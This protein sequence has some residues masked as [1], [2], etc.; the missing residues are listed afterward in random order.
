[1]NDDLVQ[2]KRGFG[3]HPHSNAEIVTYI[4][5][6]K[7][8]H[9]DSMHTKETLGPGSIQFMTAGSGVVH[10]EHNLQDEPLRFIQMWLTPKQRGLEPNYG[11]MCGSKCNDEKNQWNHLVSST[12]TKVKTPVEINTDANIYVAKLEEGATVNMKLNSYRQ[13][14]VLAVDGTP[15]I[16]AKSFGK[17]KLNRHDAAELYGEETFTFTGPGHVLLVEMAKDGAGGRKD[18]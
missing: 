10:S 9:K 4:V 13:A 16:S 11:S 17:Q 14:Y 18:L 15:T 12:D 1:M 8:T 6:G 2:P 3:S 7:L 5:E